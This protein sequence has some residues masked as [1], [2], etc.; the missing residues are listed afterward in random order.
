ML[1]FPSGEL[2]RIDSDAFA[3]LVV[4]SDMTFTINI[5]AFAN[6]QPRDI[7]TEESD[8][9][10][11]DEQ[12]Q[13]EYDVKT[14]S[15]KSDLLLNGEI[16]VEKTPARPG[17]YLASNA[18]RGLVIKQ[19][20]RLVI[21]VKNY[22]RVEL[23]ANS[24]NN[25]KQLS[26]S[27]FNLNVE[28]ASLV[29]FRSKCADGWQAYTDDYVDQM[30]NK[31]K[32]RDNED[33]DEE[34]DDDDDEYSD[35]DLS[36]NPIE[37]VLFKISV[38]EVGR[39]LF[40]KESFSNL[41]LFNASTFQIGVSRFDQVVLG[42]EA[43][44]GIKQQKASNFELNLSDGR[45]VRMSEAVFSDLKQGPMAKFFLYFGVNESNMC[46]KKSTFENLIQ[47]ANSTLRVTFNM[48]AQNSLLFAGDALKD[49]KQNVNSVVQ[50]YALRVNELVLDAECIS[51]L[52]QAKA[53]VFEIW[54]SKA[55]S[56]FTVRPKAFKNVKQAVESTIR[57]GFTSS[58]KDSYYLQSRD[59]FDQIYSAE[60]SEIV[61]D[62][63]Q[64][65]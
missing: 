45:A 9:D 56:N 5:G 13:I 21:N 47:A 10:D 40:E 62:F 28:K 3:G 29:L 50:I 54:V 12:N 30:K 43:F 22:E 33:A 2:R 1:S 18:F 14:P 26:S 15:T 55:K 51:G 31:L 20:G 58:P 23:T 7:D 63:T 32:K 48:N 4:D 37:N 34:D 60:K 24:L 65:L 59:A 27:A 53:S 46:I 42:T 41:K 17:L 44:E 11:S 38:R 35:R 25:M 19:G 36:R 8:Q 6:D 16:Q 64:G 61:Y 39:V 49:V 52:Q 57:L